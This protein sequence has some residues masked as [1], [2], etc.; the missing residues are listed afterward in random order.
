MGTILSRFLDAEI[1]LWNLK[2]W[3]INPSPSSNHSLRFEGNRFSCEILCSYP[4]K[5]DVK[6][7]PIVIVILSKVNIFGKAIPSINHRSNPRHT[8]TQIPIPKSNQASPKWLPTPGAFYSLPH[9]WVY[10]IKVRAWN[11][12]MLQNLIYQQIIPR[13]SHDSGCESVQSWSFLFS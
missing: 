5:C 11:T 4:T 8:H 13:A 2:L 10:R 1:C 9:I 6:R 3:S 12:D 7:L